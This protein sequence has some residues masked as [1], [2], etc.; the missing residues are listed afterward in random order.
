MTPALRCPNCF[1]KSEVIDSRETTY[2]GAPSIRRRRL[3]H[4][5]QLRFTT[6]EVRPEPA[7]KEA[8]P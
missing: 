2:Q 5:C 7:I 1:Q 4:G 8:V 3:C 6:Y